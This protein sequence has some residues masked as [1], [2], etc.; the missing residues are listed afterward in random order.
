MGQVTL[1]PVAFLLIRSLFL[2]D[3]VTFSQM[4][5]KTK[6]HLFLGRKAMTNLDAVIKKQRYHFAD[7]GSVQSSHP[8][9][10]DS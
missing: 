1:L 8:V 9:V 10:F 5:N 2:I 6:I 7:K 4:L 3:L